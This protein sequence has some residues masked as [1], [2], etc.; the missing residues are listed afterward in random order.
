[1]VISIQVTPSFDIFLA[2]SD[3]TIKYYDEKG[4]VMSLSHDTHC[5]GMHG[6][7]LKVHYCHKS[8]LLV[9]AFDNGKVHIRK[10]TL[11]LKNHLSWRESCSSLYDG[12][13]DILDM[14]CLLQAS[15]ELECPVFELWFGLN[16]AQVEIW[17]MPTS[18]NQVLTGTVSPPSC[19]PLS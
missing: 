16:S 12:T 11:G 10:C 18:P 3:G 17:R 9:L 4:E 7:I 19:R 15:C 1:M 8:K 13:R 5:P 14:E 2:C 6:D